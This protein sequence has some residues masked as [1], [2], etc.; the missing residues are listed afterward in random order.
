[1]LEGALDHFYDTDVDTLLREYTRYLGKKRDAENPVQ[2]APMGREEAIAYFS[3]IPDK[4]KNNEPLEMKQ[5]M[6]RAL[7]EEEFAAL[8][9]EQ[10]QSH[11]D[12]AAEIRSM[13]DFCLKMKR[14]M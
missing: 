14:M 1:M 7:T 10:A 5:E 2:K 9:D 12:I 4:C 3:A 11:S 6:L 13:F 8:C